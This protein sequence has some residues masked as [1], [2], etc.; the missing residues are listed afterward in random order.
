MAGHRTARG[1]LRRERLL[2][3][4]AELVAQRGFHAVGIADIGAAA[5]VTGSAI[6]RH[7]ETKV[8]LLVALFDRVVDDLND[9]AQSAV[10]T[11]GD[12][13]DALA[14]LVRAH[15]AF[16]LGQRA[17]VMVYRQEAHNLPDIDRRRLRRKQR[18]Y[19]ETWTDALGRLHPHLPRPSVR[20]AVHAVFG[21]IN[22]VADFRSGLA[23]DEL[24]EILVSLALAALSV[25][26]G[27]VVASTG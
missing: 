8:D 18:A 16:A 3:A 22:S 19:A 23:D 12:A 24:S 27:S 2:N 10:A 6:Y 15:V 4:A 25:P 26:V 13:G 21:M 7:F 11:A 17:V 14:M 20:A 5:G 9:A 1:R